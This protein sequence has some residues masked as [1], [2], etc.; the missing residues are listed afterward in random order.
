MSRIL[1]KKIKIMSAVTGLQRISNAYLGSL[2]FTNAENGVNNRTINPHTSVS[3]G[4]T[5]IPW[6]ESKDEFKEKHIKIESKDKDLTYYIWQQ[7]D[8][9]RCTR[10]GWQDSAPSINGNS[11][12]SQSVYWDIS[13]KGIIT[14]Y[15]EK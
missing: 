3:V 10:D 13:S 5:W 6:C 14:Q 1:N 4:N 11:K 2:T 12:T 7:G 9:I 15:A 8:S